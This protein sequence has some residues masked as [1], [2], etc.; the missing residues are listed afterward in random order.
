MSAQRFIS[1]SFWDDQ[2]VQTLNLT[3]KALFL[4]L[5]TNTLTNIAGVYKITDRRIS[6]DTGLSENELKEIMAKFE[7]SGKVYRK[8]EYIILPNWTK[9]QKWESH[10]KIKAGIDSIL[11]TLSRDMLIF[12][13]KSGY[14]YQINIVIDSL[15]KPINDIP[16]SE[17]TEDSQSKPSNYSDS[18]LDTN[19][20]LDSNS[21]TDLQDGEADI[22]T[23]Q[24][25]FMHYWQHNPDIFNITAS[26]D[27]FNKWQKYWSTSPPS[28]DQI[29][30]AMENFIADVKSG[31]IERRYIP[32]KPD[33][34]I[35]GNWI[36]TCQ[37]RRRKS[38]KTKKISADQVP[39]EEVTKYFKQSA[40]Q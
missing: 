2:W 12:L 6:F 25:I 32:S 16:E 5:M 19:I 1:T 23:S 9:H 34:F 27:D 31:D 35:S 40:S 24:K 28:C 8:D 18:N 4:Y 36:N 13:K 37:E 15:S 20:N 26:F 39:P 7:K 3:E 21:N 38:D 30:R 11:K 33:L 10:A 17:S 22:S 29:K 14:A